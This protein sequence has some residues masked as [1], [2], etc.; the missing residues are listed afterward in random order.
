MKK[1]IYILTGLAFF[2]GA[3]SDNDQL[4]FDKPVDERVNEKVT[5][6]KE[7]LVTS[8]HGWRTHYYPN[9]DLLGGFSFV[10]KFHEDGVVETSWD[11][12]AGIDKS[13]Y[14]VKAVDWPLLSFDTYCIF[15]KM[16]DP[17]IGGQGVGMGGEQE[18]LYDRLSESGDT[19]FLNGKTKGEPV[20]FVK[21]SQQDWED[22]ENEKYKAMEA[23]LAEVEGT[24]S[25]YRVLSVDGGNREYVMVYYPDM[26]RAYV[27][28]INESGEGDVINIGVNFTATGFELQYP[29]DMGNEKF[30]RTFSFDKATQE[31]TALDQGVQGGI[32]FE[33]NSPVTFKG[34]AQMYFYKNWSSAS[35]TSPQLINSMIGIEEI[36]EFNNFYYT[37]YKG[38]AGMEEI[39]IY[40]TDYTG[41]GFDIAQYEKIGEDKVVLH[42]GGFSSSDYDE[43]ILENPG[44]KALYDILFDPAGWTI[45]PITTD[46]FGLRCYW[47][48][49]SDPSMYIRFDNDF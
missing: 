47:V 45:V 9:K 7:I 16:T 4:V 46:E 40:F 23:V 25:F 48:N 10:F 26:R 22:F 36:E 3:C 21:A 42:N 35:Y 12:R 28:Y 14:T 5:E 24:H 20:V 15:S 34:A 1:L 38:Q 17:E 2:F 27:Y 44:V 37:A 39:K 18:L 32:A 6:L 29:L 33:E 49:N 41:F 30:V 11:L 19:L 13:Y 8:E 43:S 31:Y